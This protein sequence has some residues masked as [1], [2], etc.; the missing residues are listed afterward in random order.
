MIFLRLFKSETARLMLA[1]FTVTALGIAVAQ[2]GHAADTTAP[3]VA[4]R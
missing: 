4:S 2:P 3:V 1:G